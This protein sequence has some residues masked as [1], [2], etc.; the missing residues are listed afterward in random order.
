M[1]K[2]F[3]NENQ[4][5]SPS[6]SDNG[7]LKTGNKADL[8]GLL[9]ALVSSHD[10]GSSPT[11][12]AITLEGAA[13]VNMLSTGMQKQFLTMLIPTPEKKFGPYVMNQMKYAKRVDV[14][15]DTY[16]SDSLKA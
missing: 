4:G 16:L 10:T 5:Y 13:F 14:V 11:V 9:E 8:L 6:I 12:D 2:F 3:E 15:W 7:K 1:K